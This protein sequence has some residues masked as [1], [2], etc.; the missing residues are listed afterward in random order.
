[1]VDKMNQPNISQLWYTEI[2]C[3]SERR[4]QRSTLTIS[5]THLHRLLFVGEWYL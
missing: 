2:Q 5:P 1:M 4:V 3:V